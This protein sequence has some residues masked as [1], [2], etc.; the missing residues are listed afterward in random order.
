[1][2]ERRSWRGPGTGVK[3]M[4]MH[5][6]RVVAMAGLTALA[7]QP[8]LAQP[9]RYGDGAPT[10]AGCEALGFRPDPRRY[11]ARPMP[12]APPPRPQPRVR[13]DAPTIPPLPLPPVEH[14]LAEPGP[15]PPA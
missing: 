14:R 11:D 5:R 4:A 3:P 1:M 9:G 15:P 13:R 12:I 7:G 6:L 2:S 10:P 8:T